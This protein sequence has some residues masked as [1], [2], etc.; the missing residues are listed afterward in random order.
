MKGQETYR[1]ELSLR[2]R[3]ARACWGL[4]WGLF[5]RSSPRPFH[6]WRRLWLRLFGAHL[7]A[8]AAVYPSA[9]VWAPWNLHM[10]PRTALGDGVDCYNVA[11]IT[12]DEGAIVSQYAFLCTASHDL[13]DP[14][15]RL[16][17]AP[18]HLGRF[19][20]VCAAAFVHPGITLGE[21]AVAGARAVVIKDVAPWH[22]VA[23]NPATFLKSRV[24]FADAAP[25]LPT[26]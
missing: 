13:D 9:R 15:R 26:D 19:S 23:G 6:G 11:R 16:I 24:P 8:T 17:T 4:V 1:S 22:V 7:D 3:V 2:N 21:G 5:C 25:K 14:G 20:W 18:I 10:G 12:L